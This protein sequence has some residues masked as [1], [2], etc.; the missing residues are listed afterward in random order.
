MFL[1]FLGYGLGV[2][3]LWWLLGLK[4]NGKG[5]L[6]KQVFLLQAHLDKRRGDR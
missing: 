1:V 4:T 6:G 5:W 3:S 2:L